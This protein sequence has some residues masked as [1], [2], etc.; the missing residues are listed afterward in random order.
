MATLDNFDS[1]SDGD[2]N[3]QGGWTAN[4]S[5]DIQGVTVQSGAKAV[6]RPGG[7]GGTTTSTKSI[8]PITTNGS[9]VSF[10]IR[11]TTVNDAGGGAFG[12]A[13]F[14][15]TN[16]IAR[17]VI[18]QTTN[19]IKLIGS[20]TV[21]LLAGPSI[22]TWYKITLE[23]NFGTDTVR[24]KVDNSSYSSVVSGASGAF[25]QVDVIGMVWGGTSGTSSFIDTF[26]STLGADSS[27]LLNF[28]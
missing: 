1:Y 19:N 8:T 11:S 6:S 17:V 4:S 22:D 3:L 25:S 10:Y 27:F 20:T 7:L 18:D 21:E 15:S 16:E 14:S 23:I 12:G 13:I 9:T 28:I 5:V 2:L 26:E 24:A